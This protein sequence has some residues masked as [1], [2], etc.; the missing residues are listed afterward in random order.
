MS[1]PFSP[2]FFF[3]DTATTEIY[4]L[5]LH[6]ALPISGE[7]DGPPRNRAG[8]L[9]RRGAR[10]GTRRSHLGR[11]R[12]STRLNSSHVE[13]SY[14]VF[15]LKKKKK[16]VLLKVLMEKQGRVACGARSGTQ[17]RQT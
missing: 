6:D 7:E 12:K 3:T 4:P 5:S 2:F 1:S 11:D 15:C 17:R 10:S 9:D 13:I 8:S 16:Y 14:A